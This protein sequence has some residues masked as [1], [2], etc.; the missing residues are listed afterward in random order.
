MTVHQYGMYLP[1]LKQMIRESS[2]ITHGF[3]F[4]SSP[5]YSFYFFLAE[6]EKRKLT[7]IAANVQEHKTHMV[8]TYEC[9]YQNAKEGLPKGIYHLKAQSP[10]CVCVT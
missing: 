5:G 9:A 7:V 3:I 6:S 8:S 2:R 1:K 10:H 4:T